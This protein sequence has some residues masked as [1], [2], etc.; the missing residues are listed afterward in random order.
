MNDNGH[1]DKDVVSSKYLPCVKKED[2][3]EFYD[4]THAF[5]GT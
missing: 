5:F 1:V 4:A 2:T 3:E